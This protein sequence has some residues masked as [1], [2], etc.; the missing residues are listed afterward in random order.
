MASFGR[1][2]AEGAKDFAAGVYK[3]LDGQATNKM[4]RK[5]VN[6]NSSQLGHMGSAF[7]KSAPMKGIAGSAQDYMK[8]PK[9]QRNMMQSIKM[10]HMT[11]VNGQNVLDMKKVAGTAATVGVAGRVVTGGGLYRDRYGNVN[12]PGLPFI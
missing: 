8:T 6:R 5:M 12:V 3:G 10:G 1:L 9:G 7:I 4:T 11:K 2:L